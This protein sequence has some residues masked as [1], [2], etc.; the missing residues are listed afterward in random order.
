MSWLFSQALVEE[1]L[2]GNFSDGTQS[3]QSNGSHTQQAYCAPDKMT[4]FSRLSQS[5]MMFKPLMENH[6]GALLM[7]YLE[8][9]HAKTFQP[10]GGGG[11]HW[12]KKFNVETHGQDHLRGGTK[13]RLRGK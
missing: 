1:Y 2:A 7:S 12:R 8:A 3:A 4:A 6:G 11:D 13:I 5:G 10:L 9:F